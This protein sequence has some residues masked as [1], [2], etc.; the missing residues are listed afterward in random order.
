MSYIF[1]S[2]AH[3]IATNATSSLIDSLEEL[4]FVVWTDRKISSGEKWRD[5]IDNAIRECFAVI[6]VVTPKAVQSK[7]VTYEWA[8][9]MGLDKPVFTVLIESTPIGDFHSKLEEIQ[10]VDFTLGSESQDFSELVE[11]LRLAKLKT[12][13]RPVSRPIRMAVEKLDDPTPATWQSAIHSLEHSDDPAAVDALADAVQH[14]SPGVVISAAKALARKTKYK[15]NRAVKGLAKALRSD[16]QSR[17][18]A[19][20]ILGEYKSPEAAQALIQYLPENPDEHLSPSIFVALRRIG[21]PVSAP[22]LFEGLKHKT[23]GDIVAISAEA[24][25]DIGELNAIPEIEEVIQKHF[26]KATRQ[27]G[28][29]ALV[30]LNAQQSIPIIIKALEDEDISVRVEAA[31]GLAKLKSVSSIPILQNAIRSEMARNVVEEYRKALKQLQEL[32]IASKQN[33]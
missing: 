13:Q 20:N 15:D 26:W 29:R 14:P 22:A 21:S 32:D 19:I 27:A 28:I 10:Y 12:E 5:A 3:N 16:Y 8:F 1:L 18:E 33:V 11:N 30:A 24:L 31:H 6:V 9:A 4:D 25:G 2:Y 23:Q 17:Q 7:Y